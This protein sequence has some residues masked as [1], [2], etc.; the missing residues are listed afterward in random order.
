MPLATRIEDR[1]DSTIARRQ[2]SGAAIGRRFRAFCA[3]SK[4]AALATEASR[5][6][7]GK[8][9]APSYDGESRWHEKR[10]SHDHL[11]AARLYW[12]DCRR[13][14]RCL[15]Q[16]SGCSPV[17][18]CRGSGFGGV[19]RPCR[20]AWPDGSRLGPEDLPRTRK[21]R[22]SI[23]PVRSQAVL[24]RSSTVTAMSAAVQRAQS[25]SLLQ[26]QR[27]RQGHPPLSKGLAYR[28]SVG[29]REDLPRTRKTKASIPPVR[30]QAVLARSSTVTAMSAAVQRV[31]SRS[32]LQRQRLRRGHPPLP[33]SL[34]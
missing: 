12:H 15:R 13:L 19:I 3:A 32:F 34:A 18:C 7:S 30:S 24:A 33:T 23:P 4:S 2:R 25:R 11:Y 10:G 14:L 26:G 29:R 31:Q 20:G 27:R 16:S 21:T 5:R 8:T 17:R 9:S 28:Q 6:K 22:T 1:L